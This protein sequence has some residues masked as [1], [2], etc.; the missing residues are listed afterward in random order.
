VSNPFLT[1]TLRSKTKH[2]FLSEKKVNKQLGAKGRVSS[3]SIEGFKGDGVLPSWLLEHKSTVNKS[4][5]LKQTDLMKISKQA[6]GINRLPVLTLSFVM[7]DGTPLKD[8]GQWAILPLSIF[9]ELI[10]VDLRKKG[11]PKKHK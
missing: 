11:N 7:P 6:M 4:Y 5:K 8:M 10:S 1:R 2:G 3:G 9:K